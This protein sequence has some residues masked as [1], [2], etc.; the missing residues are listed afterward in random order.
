MTGCHAARKA[1]AW[2]VIASVADAATPTARFDTADADE[3]IAT[4]SLGTRTI[5]T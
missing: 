3:A 4:F 5:G 1:F 2:F